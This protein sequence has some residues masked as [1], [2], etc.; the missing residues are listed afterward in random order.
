MCLALSVSS[1]HWHS[2]V[3]VWEKSYWLH[4][5]DHFSRLFPLSLINRTILGSPSQ[6]QQQLQPL[7]HISKWSLPAQSP[8][9]SWVVCMPVYKMAIWWT[10]VFNAD[11]YKA[12]SKY[13][14]CHVPAHVKGFPQK[15]FI[16]QALPQT[17]L[18]LKVYP[19]WH[20]CWMQMFASMAFSVIESY[21]IKGIK[22][23]WHY[24]GL[25]NPSQSHI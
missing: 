6:K 5:S 16:Q 24:S 10:L 9:K 21:V 22:D 17:L 20:G 3:G 23:T 4:S 19:S 15:F 13:T 11:P 14:S 7:C 2:L 18:S 1:C 12:H 8:A 25:G